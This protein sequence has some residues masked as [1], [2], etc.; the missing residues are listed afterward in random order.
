MKTHHRKSASRRARDCAQA[1]AAITKRA[2]ELDPC[3]WYTPAQKA[4]LED[5]RFNLFKRIARLGRFAALIQGD[6]TLAAL[7]LH[8]AALEAARG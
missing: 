7:K 3:S 5:K 2:A 6:V 8:A 4:A 1:I